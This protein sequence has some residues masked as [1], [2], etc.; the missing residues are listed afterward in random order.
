[1]YKDLIPGL[2]SL[3]TNINHINGFYFSDNFSFYK[4]IRYKNKF[5]YKIS[6]KYNIDLPP[7]YEFRNGHYYKIGD[8]CYY[9]GNYF[10]FYYYC[11]CIY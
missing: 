4:N 2:V 1:M 3:D 9:S 11:E 5:H 7:K 6:K 8:F 10:Y